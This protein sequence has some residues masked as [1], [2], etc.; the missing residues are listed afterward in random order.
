ML[1]NLL[2]ESTKNL[3]SQ[4][5]GGAMRTIAPSELSHACP[6]SAA[7]GPR[8]GFVPQA[9]T[10]QIFAIGGAP[11]ATLRRGLTY[12]CT[13]ETRSGRTG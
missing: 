7:G 5:R 12:H 11:A 8:R 9:P 2:K 1:M 10:V 3:A 4:S 13:D 6:G